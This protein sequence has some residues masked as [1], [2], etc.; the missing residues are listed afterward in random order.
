MV[1]RTINASDTEDFFNMMCRLDEETDYM[2]YEP[3]ERQE[4]TKDL[5]HLAG[6]IEAAESG[7]DFLLCAADETGEIVGFI[8]A[9]L[10]D[11]L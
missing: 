3:G 2:M 6:I 10:S 8:M 11:R 1:F 7:G 5:S 4:R 9:R